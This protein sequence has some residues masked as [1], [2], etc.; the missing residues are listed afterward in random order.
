MKI[1]FIIANTWETAMRLNFENECVPYRKRIVTIDLTPEQKEK[2]ILRKVGVDRGQD[3]YE[4]II[5]CFIENEEI[6]NK[7][8]NAI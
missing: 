8:E 4:E 7:E 3:V 2:L 6:I 5:E 1:T